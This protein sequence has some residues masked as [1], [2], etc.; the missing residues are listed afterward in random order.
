LLIAALGDGR[1]DAANMRGIVAGFGLDAVSFIV[2][3]ITLVRTKQQNVE[4]SGNDDILDS[5]RSGLKFVWNDVPLRAVF[6][7]VAAITF[8]FNGPFNVGILCLPIGASPKGRSHLARS[9]P[10]GVQ[11]HWWVCY[12]LGCCLAL[13]Q[14]GWG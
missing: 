11:A 8:F 1:S 14:N 12:W 13:T 6:F 3:L 9:C 4:S 2:S 10:P 5:I 7:V